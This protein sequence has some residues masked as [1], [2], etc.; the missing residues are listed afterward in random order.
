[1]NQNCYFKTVNDRTERKNRNSN[2]ETMPNSIQVNTGAPEP[3]Q[4]ALLLIERTEA[5]RRKK[6]CNKAE[7]KRK[8]EDVNSL[9]PIRLRLHKKIIV[10]SRSDAHFN[11]LSM[12]KEQMFLHLL[13][14]LSVACSIDVFSDS[15]EQASAS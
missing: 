7:R 4:P 12:D 1:M 14:R 11:F 2:V 8:S 13:S 9:Y 10:F 3:N 6:T 5:I 15:F